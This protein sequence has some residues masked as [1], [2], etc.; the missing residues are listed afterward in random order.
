MAQKKKKAPKK[1][2]ARIGLSTVIL[3]L[4]LLAG[5]A[6]KMNDLQVQ[7]AAAE[8]QYVAL[9][10]QVESQSQTNEQLREAIEQGGTQEQME[11]IAREELGLTAPGEKVFYDISN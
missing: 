7:V 10:A 9:E 11:Q 4:I 8:E 6:W 2:K 3:I 1:V 5:F